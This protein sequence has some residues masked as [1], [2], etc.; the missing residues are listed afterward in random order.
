MYLPIV[1]WRDYA[2]ACAQRWCGHLPNYFGH[3]SWF[4]FYLETGSVKQLRKPKITVLHYYYYTRLTAL[5]LALPIWI[6]LVDSEWQWHQLGSMQVCTSLQTDNHASTP[7]LKFFYRPDALPAAQP[8]ASK[9]WRTQK[10]HAKFHLDTS[11]QCSFQRNSENCTSNV[12]ISS[13][14]HQTTELKIN[15]LLSWQNRRFFDIFRPNLANKFSKCIMTHV[16]Q[17]WHYK[18]GKWQLLIAKKCAAQHTTVTEPRLQ[19]QD[20]DSQ[21]Q[22]ETQDSEST[23]PGLSRDK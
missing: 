22:G 19:E 16:E 11:H 12:V 21:D 13:N 9:H 7:P 14:L 8:T 10:L 6:L 17:K 5:F 23:V 4:G 18:I 20:T 1:Q 2:K 3:L 15:S